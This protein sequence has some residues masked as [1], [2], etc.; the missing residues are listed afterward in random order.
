[1]ENENEIEIDQPCQYIFKIV[2]VGNSGVGKTSL[3][4]QFVHQRS[5]KENIPTIGI[6]YGTK[7]LN[8]S[9]NPIKLQI[10]DTAGQEKYRSF[11]SSYY[12]NATLA[13]MVYDVTDLASFQEL[14]NWILEIRESLA[15]PLMI[16]GNKNDLPG[17]RQVSEKEVELLAKRFNGFFYETSAYC[18]TSCLQ[19]INLL[20]E[21]LIEYNQEGILVNDYSRKI[22]NDSVYL[23]PTPKKKFCCR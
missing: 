15:V 18:K 5:L 20:A 8:L 11:I 21:K 9:G 6:D 10:W 23:R 2:M 16:I 13:V 14:E 7:N 17:E 12:R 1:M 19:A 22:F 3:L 4:Y